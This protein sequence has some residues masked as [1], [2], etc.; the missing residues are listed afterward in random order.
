MTHKDFMKNIVDYYGKYPREFLKDTVFT[1]IESTYLESELN[2]LLKLIIENYPT[3]YGNQP[4]VFAIEMIRKEYNKKNVDYI[5]YAGG[6]SER[7]G[8]PLG[9]AKEN[10]IIA[11][12]VEGLTKEKKFIADNS[13]AGAVRDI[14]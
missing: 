13:P 12:M 8:E 14:K 6:R 9:I 2:F 7:V 1:Y 11:I 4:D 10:S 5:Q 3:Q